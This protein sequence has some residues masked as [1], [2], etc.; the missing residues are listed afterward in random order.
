VHRHVR[1]SGESGLELAPAEALKVVDTHVILFLSL[2]FFVLKISLPISC[3]ISDL[4][5]HILYTQRRF[6]C[7]FV[8][9]CGSRRCLWRERIG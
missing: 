6:G 7:P 5:V 1:V 9:L 8:W 4:L 2:S 3:K